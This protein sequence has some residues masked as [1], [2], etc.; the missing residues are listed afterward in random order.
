MNDII[1]QSQQFL[2]SLL[3][4][5]NSDRHLITSIF[6]DICLLNIWHLSFNP[7][8]FTFIDLIKG[9]V[10]SELSSC[11]LRLNSDLSINRS[12]ISNLLNFI[13]NSV[14]KEVWL[15]RCTLTKSC[16]LSNNITTSSK[17]SRSRNSSLLSTSDLNLYNIDYSLDLVPDRLFSWSSI[18]DYSFTSG[19]LFSLFTRVVTTPL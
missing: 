4:T 15:P 5:I 16:E 18:F 7:R 14:L 17:R 9:F 11:L 12:V 3:R 1:R 13:Y 6:A 8:S 2:L 19:K 10:P